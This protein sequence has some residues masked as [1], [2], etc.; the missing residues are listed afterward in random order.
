MKVNYNTIFI[1]SRTPSQ[2]NNQM[3]LNIIDQGIADIYVSVMGE[4]IT[5]YRE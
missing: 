5:T 4:N 1:S 2:K 3:H